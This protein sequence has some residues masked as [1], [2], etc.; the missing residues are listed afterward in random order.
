MFIQTVELSQHEAALQLLR[1]DLY[2]WKG[3]I[4]ACIELTEYLWSKA[5]EENKPFDFNVKKLVERFEVYYTV[6]LF[7]REHSTAFEHPGEIADKL[8]IVTIP[9][10]YGRFIAEVL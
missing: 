6:D 4:E 8:N 7:N 1:S 2:P 9:I 5:V 10:R 3:D